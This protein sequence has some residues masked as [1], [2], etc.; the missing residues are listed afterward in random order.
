MSAFGRCGERVQCG[1]HFGAVARCTDIFK[2]FNLTITHFDV[3]DGQE[4]EGIFF[5]QFVFVHAH[6]DVFARVNACLFFCGSRFN[7]ELG[8]AAVYG[9]GH[10]AH[11]FHFFN[12]GPG[13]V[14]H[15]LRERLHH[16]AARPG[17]DHVGDVRLFL[18]D[19]LRVAGNA[20]AELGRQGNGFVKAVG[21]QR[22]CAAKYGR[23]GFNGG[24]HH[25][26]VGVLLGE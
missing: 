4:I 26:V 19:Q 12:D 6:N 1:L 21:V 11:G 17:V 24:A 23:H 14:G 20:R 18:N 2:S 9:L 15:L 7:F 22:L 5:G 8:P 16:V 10:A 3:V 25:V 13:F